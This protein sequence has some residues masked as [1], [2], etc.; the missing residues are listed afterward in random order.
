MIYKL[1][2]NLPKAEINKRVM[3]Y[4]ANQAEITQLKAKLELCREALATFVQY[5]T[6]KDAP[7]NLVKCSECGKLSF[8][9]VPICMDC[10]ALKATE[11]LAAIE[12]RD[13]E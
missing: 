10:A 1:G 2:Y 12:G 4:E 8:R 5:Y 6:A 9:D 7:V 11:A 3:A 13:E